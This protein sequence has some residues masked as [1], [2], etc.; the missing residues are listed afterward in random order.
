MEE[1][2]EQQ[3]GEEQEEEEKEKEK[4]TRSEGS[5]QRHEQSEQNATGLLAYLPAVVADVFCRLSLCWPWPLDAVL[6]AMLMGRRVAY[7]YVVRT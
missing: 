1:K 3:E 4:E 5:N 7:S 6:S 2:Y